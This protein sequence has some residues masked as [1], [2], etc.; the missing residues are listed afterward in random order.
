MGARCIGKWSV[1]VS[2]CCVRTEAFARFTAHCTLALALAIPHLADARTTAVGSGVGSPSAG[3]TAPAAAGAAN[4]VLGADPIDF[5][6]GQ[7]YRFAHDLTVADIIPLDLVR[8]YRSGVYDSPG[9][10][11]V[12]AFGVGMNL[13]YDD[14]LALSG[15]QQRFELREA[16]GAKES[17]T[18]RPGNDGAVWDNLTRSSD[19][20][21]AR[22][23][24]NGSA[25]MKLTLQDGYVEQF[26][27]IAGLYRLIRLQDRNGNELTITR[28]DRTGAVKGVAGPG[29]RVLAFTT[30]VGSHGTPLVSS[31][32][33]PLNRQI[34]YQYD[35]RDRLV[36]VTN[37]GGGL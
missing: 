18:A 2:L 30:V 37:A 6:T 21:G 20:Y 1:A 33:D 15:D 13:G 11:Y 22:I 28:D 32:T 26:A 12:G 9:M 4:S 34:T 29:G 3:V 27:L 7:F 5:S 31:V 17:F 36:R 8:I 25:G 19:Y 16:A 24:A 10:P 23:D 14:V 35:N